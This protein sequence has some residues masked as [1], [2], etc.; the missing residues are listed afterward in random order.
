MSTV[1]GTFEA[2]IDRL[3][4]LQ[5]LDRRLKVKQEQVAALM[6]E[7]ESFEQEMARQRE[8]LASLTLE[9]DNL[10]KQRAEMDARL[11]L[12]GVKIRDSRMRLNRVRNDRE[13]LALQREIDLGKE[14]N[15]LLE[16]QL[17]EVMERLESLDQRLGE[18][19]E[20]LE[21]LEGQ[22]EEEVN[23]KRN[24]AAT[25]DRQAASDRKQRDL[26]VRG[27]DPALRGKYERIFA[28]RGGTAVVEVRGGTC[29]GCHMNVPPQLFNELQR[30]RDIRQCPNCHRILYF[31]PES[32]DGSGDG[33]PR[34][35]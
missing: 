12:E 20:G 26:L 18:V 6:G 28:R 19:R 5:E 33:K 1:E 15:H 25:I 31:Q 35:A 16:E 21:A 17:I 24:E 2:E 10:E 27:M 9:R 29:L 4:A 14:A 11:E 8:D 22:A 13:M 7:A 32:S 30:H 3:A 23:A 34:G